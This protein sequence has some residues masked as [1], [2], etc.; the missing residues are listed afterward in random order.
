MAQ[1]RGAFSFA[2]GP[3]LHGS[4]SD[5]LPASW[6][7][8]FTFSYETPGTHG[9]RLDLTLTGSGSHAQT[10][11]L[12]NEIGSPIG[13]VDFRRGGSSLLL[14]ALYRARLGRIELATGLQGG[15]TWLR[16]ILLND[17]IG[18]LAQA[19]IAYDDLT[20]QPAWVQW[21]VEAAVML[22]DEWS[23]YL[24]GAIGLNNRLKRSQLATAREHSVR[25]GVRW[26]F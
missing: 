17:N 7:G 23:L 13:Q 22:S 6:G 14:G 12:T 3:N 5:V 2:T 4:F 8:H 1:D 20:L 24:Q 26:W 25:L 21:P 15:V 11:F 18:F 16:F 10:I 9:L 19:D